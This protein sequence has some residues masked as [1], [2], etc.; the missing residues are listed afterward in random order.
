MMSPDVT[1]AEVGK[2]E[3]LASKQ[4]CQYFVMFCYY[5][6]LLYIS[7]EILQYSDDFW[8]RC[9]YH[10]ALCLVQIQVKLTGSDIFTQ[11]HL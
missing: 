2:S 9:L 8:M 5:R 3:Q 7:N 1:K 6:T 10:L 4:I 11:A